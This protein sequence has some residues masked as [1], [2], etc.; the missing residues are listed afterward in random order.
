MTHREFVEQHWENARFESVFDNSRAWLYKPGVSLPRDRGRVLANRSGGGEWILSGNSNTK[1]EISK[2]LTEAAAWSAARQFT[3]ERLEEIR[4][5]ER[6]IEAAE[7][8]AGDAQDWHDWCVSGPYV[9][10]KEVASAIR[11]YATRC[12]ILA[13]E[14]AHLESLQRGMKAD[15][16]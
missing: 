3:E 8:E 10:D 7:A 13:R 14:R 9:P 16:P 1:F 12:R 6:E 11:R 15:R 2:A 5:V 4:Q